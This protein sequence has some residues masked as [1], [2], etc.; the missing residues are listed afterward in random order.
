MAT[1]LDGTAA[2]RGNEA[3]VDE[4][5]SDLAD[6]LAGVFSAR[7]ESRNGR[8]SYFL[9]GMYVNLDPS[10][11]TPADTIN[12]DVTQPIFEAVGFYHFSPD[13]QGLFGARYQGVEVDPSLPGIGAVGGSRDWTDGFI[14]LRLVPFQTD[15]WRLWLRGDVGVVSDS[16][17]SWNAV[18]GAGYCFNPRWSLLAAYRILANVA[19]SQ[20]S[21][22]WESLSNLRADRCRDRSIN[23]PRAGGADAIS[24][25]AGLQDLPLMI[26]ERLNQ[27]S[28][29]ATQQETGNVSAL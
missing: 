12:S 13:I 27:R 22:P 25:N 24:D 20:A 5:F 17:A 26:S 2:V 23:N 15:K 29:L 6:N 3:T 8:Y 16:E 14:G 19:S 11:K 10:T 21:P 9:D 28:C 1:S 4:D 18:V 7:F